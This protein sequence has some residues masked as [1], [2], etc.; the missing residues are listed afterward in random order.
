MIKNI[1]LTK[2]IFVI[3]LLTFINSTIYFISSNMKFKELRNNK[4]VINNIFVKEEDEIPYASSSGTEDEKESEEE[5]EE[6]P[7]RSTSRGEDVEAALTTIRRISQNERVFRHR[8]F[9]LW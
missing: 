9:F 3:V 2:I 4:E 7:I 1:D 5:I 6:E 8:S